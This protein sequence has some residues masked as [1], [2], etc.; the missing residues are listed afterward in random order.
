MSRHECLW[1]HSDALVAFTT[2]GDA[3]SVSRCLS[4][5]S[6]FDQSDLHDCFVQAGCSDSEAD[7]HTKH[8]IRRCNDLTPEIL[9]LKKRRPADRPSAPAS[10]S[11]DASQSM[12]QSTASLS[13]SPTPT[14]AAVLAPIGNN[15]FGQ[16]CFRYGITSTLSCLSET[17]SGKVKTKECKRVPITTSDCLRGYICTLDSNHQD[18]CMQAQNGLDTSGIIIAIV[19]GS[20]ILLGLGYLTF[21]CFRERKQHKR[22]AARAEAVA[23][24]R[25]AT[26]KQ[27]KQ[28]TQNVHAHDVRAPL[29][30]QSHDDASNPFE[31]HA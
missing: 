10:T 14:P 21:A 12:T 20:S 22:T 16:D 27:M 31:D 7:Q 2:C 9:E 4:S 5:L 23:V 25:A 30:Q 11:F 15:K 13:A 19:F 28:R 18:V 3:Q 8:L 24:A 1:T 6:R 29:I 17:V 26:M